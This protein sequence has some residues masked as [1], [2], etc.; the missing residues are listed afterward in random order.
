MDDATPPLLNKSIANAGLG[1]AP[2]LIQLL[3][4]S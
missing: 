4:N 3:V 2:A 1:I